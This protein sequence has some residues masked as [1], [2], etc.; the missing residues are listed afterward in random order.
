MHR[1]RRLPLIALALLAIAA[2]GSEYRGC[3]GSS[4][5][6]ADGGALPETEGGCLVDADC[7]GEDE[8]VALACVAGSCVEVG[9]ANDADGDRFSPPPCGEDCNDFDSSIFPGAAERCDG[10]DEDCDGAI[11]ED[12]PGARSMAL[13]H[14][15]AAARIVDTADGFL[16][17]GVEQTGGEPGMPSSSLGLQALA[18][19]GT[20]DGPVVSVALDAAPGDFAL[21]RRGDEV[22]VVATQGPGAPPAS[23]TLADS[24]DGWGA[25]AAPAPLGDEPGADDVALL[26]LDGQAWV[27]FDTRASGPSS[28]R[29][30]LWRSGAP[31]GLVELSVGAEDP[32]PG[33]AHDG[34]RV[35][36]TEGSATIRFFDASG[37]DA[38]RQDAPGTF[39]RGASLAPGDGFVYVAFRDAFDY[40]VTRATPEATTS[41]IAAP[42]G[43]ASDEVSIFRAQNGVLVTRVDASTI[44]AWL[45]DDDLDAYL[46]TF[47]PGQISTLVGAPTTVSLATPTD[48][49]SALLGSQP[50]TSSVA[51]LSCGT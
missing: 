10:V 7:V 16:V 49:P 43:N 47:E 39:A 24:G 36:A 4:P 33:L 6:T 5:P 19:D 23:V 13:A 3:D 25:T 30:F 50:S 51:V 17:V 26:V 32:P 38:G 11:D 8:C 35:A 27:L 31:D 34:A 28:R 44:R 42:S 12:A 2:G 20:P 41:S 14:G 29:R 37:G 45:L 9:P 46:A 21:A 22:L 15:L 18:A 48:G 40:S 1:E